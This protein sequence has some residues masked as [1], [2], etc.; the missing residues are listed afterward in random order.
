[1]LKHSYVAVLYPDVVDGCAALG[2]A[3]LYA[4]HSSTT[5][6]YNIAP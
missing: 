2:Y 5:Q 1:L 4:A 6:E 3:L